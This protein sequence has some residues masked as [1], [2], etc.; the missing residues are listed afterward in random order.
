MLDV[1]WSPLGLSWVRPRVASVLTAILLLLCVGLFH[2][3][4]RMEVT[5]K[6]YDVSELEKQ[7]RQTSYENKVLQVAVARYSNP[8]YIQQTAMKRLGLREPAANQV[9]TVRLK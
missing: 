3:W 2:V 6:E 8:E 5:R 7:I 1:T 4:L 9:V